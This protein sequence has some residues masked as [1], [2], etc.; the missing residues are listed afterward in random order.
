MG[1]GR[2]CR[3][4]G[5]GIHIQR[6]QMRLDIDDVAWLADDDRHQAALNIT[7]DLLVGLLVED[8]PQLCR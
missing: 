4:S 7:A 8:A 6:R 5:G 2:R 3:A 1:T